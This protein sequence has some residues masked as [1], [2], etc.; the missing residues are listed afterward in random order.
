MVIRALGEPIG[1]ADLR[2]DHTGGHG[3]ARLFSIGDDFLQAE[4]AVA[5]HG[6][7][8]NEHGVLRWLGITRLVG[9]M[10]AS[11]HDSAGVQPSEA[12]SQ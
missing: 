8:G 9:T 12:A 2:I 6:D 5:E 7:K 3:D 4:L 11:C 1:E 10:Q